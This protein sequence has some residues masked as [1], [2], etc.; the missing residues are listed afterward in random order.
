MIRTFLLSSIT[1]LLV[2]TPALAADS[3]DI[4]GAFKNWTAYTAGS[5][6][7]MTCYAMS[8][9]RA[10]QPQDRQTRSDFP[11]GF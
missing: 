8:A 7:S 2:A 3:A 10:M 1:A 5:G 9:P 6:S 4:L 11:D